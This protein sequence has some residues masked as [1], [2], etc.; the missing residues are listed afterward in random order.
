MDQETASSASP[1][2]SESSVN[3]V[4]P[5]VIKTNSSKKVFIFGLIIFAVIL[6]VVTVA[7]IVSFHP[8]ILSVIKKPIVKADS[9]T[10]YCIWSE[11][12]K[13]NDMGYVIDTGD[14]VIPQGKAKKIGVL[15][16]ASNLDNSYN[17]D[18]AVFRTSPLEKDNSGRFVWKNHSVVL[19]DD[20]K[21]P[22]WQLSKTQNSFT[23]LFR[24][25]DAMGDVIPII[26]GNYYFALFSGDTFINGKACQVSSPEKPNLK[27]E[28]VIN[29]KIPKFM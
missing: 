2:I 25:G 3:T 13:Q 14:E 19:G 5:S 12:P 6:V 21:W 11:D 26:D 22:S 8:D 28:P 10:L 9:L 4:Q 23:Y 20:R 27:R 7:G 16:K 17:G 24:Q 29:G 1:N 15:V 18:L